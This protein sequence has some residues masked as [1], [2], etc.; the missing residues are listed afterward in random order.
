M[1]FGNLLN[2]IF[3]ISF[4]ILALAVIGYQFGAVKVKGISL[5]TAG[6]LMAAL[7]Y[8]ILAS[9]VPS[10][11]VSGREIVLYSPE[12][13]QYFSLIASLGTVM[14]VTS[15]GLTAGPKFFRSF[16]RS[17]LSYILVSAVI[18]ISGA[19]ITA[20]FVLADE[21]LSPELAAGL[22]T[23]A[24][25]STPGLSAAKEAAGEAADSV[26]AGY[27]IAYLFGVI[28]VVLFVQLIPVI[29]KADAS[30]ERGR[31]SSIASSEPER[32]D[33]TEK[34]QTYQH[35]FYSFLLTAAAGCIIGA[36]KIPGVEFSLGN[37]GGCLLAGL[38]FGHFG[39]IGRID[40]RVEKTAL[41]VFR[42]L[43]MVL[44]L[45]GAGVPGGV[46]F[47][48]S[49]S[50][51]CFLYGVLITLL[52]MIAGYFTARKIFGM[53]LLNALGS[54]TGGMTST[55]ALGALIDS[56]GTDEV[57]SSYAASYPVALILIVIAAKLIVILF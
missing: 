45:I 8:G 24:L 7:L 33:E 46:N 48:G 16:N 19:L 12:M 4:I 1:Y 9:Y 36:V 18:I 37:S 26:I 34:K 54:V 42:E 32:S 57:T 53:E 2:S 23:G 35:G 41:Y 49:V 6:I 31:Y 22:M 20:I 50:L 21:S 11:C 28:G 3:S 43:G 13:K 56:S 51:R 40:I 38:I 55:P 27:G 10:F 39:R 47:I 30:V 52:P 25:T 29:L 14:F 15:V 17:C 44:F 5:G